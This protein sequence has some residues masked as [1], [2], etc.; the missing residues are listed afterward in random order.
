MSSR[1]V[2]QALF[3]SLPA[4]VASSSSS[5]NPGL[6]CGFDF[7][8]GVSYQGNGIDF[9]DAGL[10]AGSN[11]QRVG[12]ARET[13]C[14]HDHCAA[15]QIERSGAEPVFKHILA[16]EDAWTPNEF[17]DPDNFAGLHVKAVEFGSPAAPS[18]DEV[19]N[20]STCIDT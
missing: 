13:C 7:I 10:R 15:F 8:P 2:A 4:R 17:A 6:N 16:E 5:S 3:F 18:F 14:H 12:F 20:Y 11:S 19:D 1:Q 9:P